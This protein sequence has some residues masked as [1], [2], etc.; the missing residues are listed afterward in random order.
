MGKQEGRDIFWL[1]SLFQCYSLYVDDSLRK[2]GG[3]PSYLVN[4]MMKLNSLK[5][6]RIL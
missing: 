1:S 2:A 5:E 6:L 4:D 3:A